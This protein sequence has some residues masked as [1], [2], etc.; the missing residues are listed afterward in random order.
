MGIRGGGK[1]QDVCR[2]GKRKTEKRGRVIK[3]N[4]WPSIISPFKW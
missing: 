1:E 2:T 3:K 4:A